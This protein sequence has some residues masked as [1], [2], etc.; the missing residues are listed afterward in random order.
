MLC[1]NFIKENFI[2]FLHAVEHL[3]SVFTCFEYKNK[4]GPERILIIFQDTRTVMFISD[5]PNNI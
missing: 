5:E 4:T 1:L 2:R 3:F